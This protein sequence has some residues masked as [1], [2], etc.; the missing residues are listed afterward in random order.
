MH[1]YVMCICYVHAYVCEFVYVSVCYFLLISLIYS[2]LMSLKHNMQGLKKD[3]YILVILIVN[4]IIT[5][6]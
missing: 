3:V 1:A 6:Y 2:F 4:D 5:R